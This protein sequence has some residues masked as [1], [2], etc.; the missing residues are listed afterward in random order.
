[1]FSSLVIENL[2]NLYRKYVTDRLSAQGSIDCPT[3]I[4][5]KFYK[6]PSQFKRPIKT[7][8]LSE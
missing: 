8:R 2:F 7:G 5:A 1:M 4:N 6:H 3:S